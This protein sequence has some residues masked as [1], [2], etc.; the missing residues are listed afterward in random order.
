MTKS[1]WK[2]ID[3]IKKTYKKKNNKNKNKGILKIWKRNMLIPGR[4]INTLVLV[5]TGKEFRKV[6]IDRNKVGYKF[7][8]FAWTRKKNIKRYDRI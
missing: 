3:L 2:N 6:F 4:L 5:Y 8:E 1:R 7:G